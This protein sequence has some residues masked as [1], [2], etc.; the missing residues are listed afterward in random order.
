MRSAA[1]RQ[2]KKTHNINA[3]NMTTTSRGRKFTYNIINTQLWERE[4]ARA[5]QTIRKVGFFAEVVY[6]WWRREIPRYRGIF[7]TV[8]IVVGHFLISVRSASRQCSGEPY[9]ETFIVAYRRFLLGVLTAPARLRNSQYVRNT[10]PHAFAPWLM[11]AR[12]RIALSGWQV[13]NVHVDGVKIRL[14]GIPALS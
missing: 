2:H 12:W 5:L 1:G 13:N 11:E 3:S 4:S 9:H 8:C 10:G 14:G 7:E 6:N